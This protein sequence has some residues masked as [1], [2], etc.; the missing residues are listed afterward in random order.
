M[1]LQN[2]ASLSKRISSLVENEVLSADVAQRLI[3]KN[4]AD[5]S[6]RANMLWFCFY[7]PYLAG[8]S[9]IEC[10]FRSWGGE[11]LYN[12]HEGDPVTGKALLNI[13]TPCIV[14]AEIPISSLN[15]SFYPDSTMIRV[16]LLQR[17]HKLKN[18]IEHEGFSTNNIDSKNIVKVIEYPSDQ[19]IKLTK[20]DE[21]GASGT[22][23]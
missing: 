13:G 11:A 4:Q 10:F 9:G 15:G 1:H 21:W 23:L 2:A 22:A 19:F 14:K 12:H 18:G 20:C 7:E 16:F 8:R 6:N 5:E 3:N 17:G